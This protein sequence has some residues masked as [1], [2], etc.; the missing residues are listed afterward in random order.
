MSRRRKGKSKS[1]DNDSQ[2][3]G[4]GVIWAMPSAP[5]TQA[6]VAELDGGEVGLISVHAFATLR[7]DDG[8]VLHPMIFDPE[9]CTLE[10]L[11]AFM[12]DDDSVE[13]IAMLGP[14]EE[15]EDWMKEEAKQVAQGESGEGDD[16]DD[17]G[18]D[19]E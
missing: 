12:N 4:D 13:I 3:S 11:D 17:D 7:S 1:K 2:P 18:D 8:A 5:G 16:D 6:A 9:T 15:I 19:D 10:P 14:L